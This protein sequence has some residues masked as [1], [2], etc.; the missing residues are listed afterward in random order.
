MK[1]LKLSRILMYIPFFNLLLLIYFAIPF[2]VKYI[3]EKKH[4]WKI[5][6]Y[7]FIGA[8][9]LTIYLNLIELVKIA[10]L[11]TILMFA[12]IYIFGLILDYYIIKEMEIV[13]KKKNYIP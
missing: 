6:I 12:G 8:I 3:S 11:H 13:L 10:I 4:F 1:I 2:T 5:V 7:M 9:A